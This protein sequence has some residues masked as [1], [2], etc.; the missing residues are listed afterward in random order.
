MSIAGGEFAT[1]LAEAVE[2]AKDP[3]SEKAVTGT[4]Q[5]SRPSSATGGET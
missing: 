1:D 2:H 4:F 5:A 3:K